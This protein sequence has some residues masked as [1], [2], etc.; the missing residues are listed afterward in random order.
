[1]AAKD[2][3]L[4]ARFSDPSIWAS[5]RAPEINDAVAVLRDR[6]AVIMTGGRD[7]LPLSRA[8]EAAKSLVTAGCEYHAGI[9]LTG[10]HLMHVHVGKPLV[11]RFP[12]VAA[13]LAHEQAAY[14]DTGVEAI[15]GGWIDGDVS[16]PGLQ[17]RTRGE[18]RS[19]AVDSHAFQLLPATVLLHVNGRRD[20]SNHDRTRQ[21]EHGKQ[22]HLWHVGL[23]TQP[24]CPGVIRIKEP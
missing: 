20:G 18:S 1:M 19:G 11:G 22:H 9:F 5:L 16:G 24:V 15:R 12:T 3:R 7:L 23:G 10:Q 4:G 2:R 6:H 13:V 8:V 21:S 17:L 14:F